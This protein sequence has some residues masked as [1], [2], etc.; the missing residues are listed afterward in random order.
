MEILLLLINQIL[1]APWL[2]L[3]LYVFGIIA[4]VGSGYAVVKSKIKTEIETEL[5]TELKE[6]LSSI[7]ENITEI[8]KNMIEVDSEINLNKELN[9]KDFE[10]Y[11]TKISNLI[12]TIHETNAE[13]HNIS[14]KVDDISK[15]QVT[16][17]EVKSLVDNSAKD[18]L[19]QYSD[20]VMAALNEIKKI[21]KG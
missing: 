6:D 4:G 21:K 11:D 2:Q 14:K 13:V 17:T 20:T 18:I 10:H 16:K 7:E 5:K 15:L 1:I 8:E 9:K 12:D 3:I 19:K